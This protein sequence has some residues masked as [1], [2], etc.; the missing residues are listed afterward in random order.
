[1]SAHVEKRSKGS[2][3]IIIELGKDASGK[4][5]R[6]TKSIKGT[7]KLAEKEMYKL[8]A[9]I[10]KGTYVK[11]TQLLTSEYLKKW[12]EDYGLSNLAPST[13]DSYK[14]II[15]KHLI[16]AIG[17]VPI[18]KLEPMH[19]QSYYT[20][21]LKEGRKDGKGGLSPRTVQYHHRV[22]REALQHAMRW[23]I[24]VR[25]V[26]DSVEPPKQVKPEMKVLDVAGVDKLLKTAEAR[27]YDLIYT[28][29]Y[30]G[31]RRGELIALKWQDLDL[32]KGLAS[33]RRSM[34]RL[35]G[36]GFVFRETKTKKGKRQ[37][38]LPSCLTLLLK[39]VKQ[40]QNENKLLLGSDYQDNDLVFCN[41][42]GTPTDP[43]G[44]SKRFKTL[45]EKVG[46]PGVR[47]H[48]LRHTHATLLLAEGI[49]PKIV[50]ERLGHKTITLT[51]DTYSHVLPGLQ[52][53]A[54]A[55]LELMLG[56]PPTEE[57]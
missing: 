22:C 6:I 2:W 29:V 50:Q 24:I 39:K 5:K 21:A 12:L 57:K 8:L 4:R 52:E 20:K 17:H 43:D 31:L 25:N 30:S 44:I 1:M 19:L 53:E 3:T 13:Y 33:I 47:F 45:I 26:A 11:P 14:M 28:A 16:P 38:A 40:K 7:K 34:L 41:K 36:Q 23:Q 9:E 18:I 55:K 48:D 37:V 42:N 56:K 10:E 35:T 15:N 51:L 54:A 49:H 27:D 46:F 32:T